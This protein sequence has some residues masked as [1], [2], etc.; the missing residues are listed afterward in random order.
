MTLILLNYFFILETFCIFNI[1]IQ[2]I[3][4]LPLFQLLSETNWA[5]SSL[6]SFRK[7]FT[8][9]KNVYF[10][11]LL[12]T[13]SE[14]PILYIRNN[15]TVDFR[16]FVWKFKDTKTRINVQKVFE[17]I[18]TIPNKLSGSNFD[19]PAVLTLNSWLFC[20]TDKSLQLW[21]KI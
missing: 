4:S 18:V 6:C 16:V 11:F 10:Q 1:D 12:G 17:A 19:S 21:V 7:F 5:S 14:F 8:F 9:S 2:I 20:T 13:N 3:F 15:R